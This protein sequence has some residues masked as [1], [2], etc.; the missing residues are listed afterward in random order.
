MKVPEFIKR[1][2]IRLRNYVFGRIEQQINETTLYTQTMIRVTKVRSILLLDALSFDR[3]ANYAQETAHDYAKDTVP[4]KV[5]TSTDKTKKSYK[6]MREK[7]AAEKRDKVSTLQTYPP[8]HYSNGSQAQARE[9]ERA[10]LDKEYRIRRAQEAQRICEAD[11]ERRRVLAEEHSKVIAFDRNA[12]L[13]AARRAEDARLREQ[14]MAR[15][16]AQSSAVR[17]VSVL[18]PRTN[19]TQDLEDYDHI[20]NKKKIYDSLLPILGAERMASGVGLPS[21]H[22]G[23]E[24]DPVL[25]QYNQ[26][27]YVNDVLTQHRNHQDMLRQQLAEQQRLAAEQLEEQKR[28]AA[29]QEAERIDKALLLQQSLSLYKERVQT[30]CR[31]GSGFYDVIEKLLDAFNNGDH[32]GLGE[33]VAVLTSGFLEPIHAALNAMNESLCSSGR[34]RRSLR[35]CGR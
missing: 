5:V 24:G 30:L 23:L 6:T 33:A 26:D 27:K 16:Q 32:E 14:F 25:K 19:H 3:F 13:K 18:E 34:A 35:A 29:Q 31:L 20:S 9:D 12:K 28:L 4:F 15:T 2:A 21:G 22:S 7:E 11:A 1:P 8:W 10:R 17:Y